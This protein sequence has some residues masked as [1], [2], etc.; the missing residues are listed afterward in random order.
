MAD[1]VLVTGAGGCLGAWAVRLLMLEGTAVVGLDVSDDSHRLRML[2]DDDEMGRV[3]LRRGDLR[4]QAAVEALIQ[5]EGITHIV[6]L[7]ALQVPFCRADPVLGAQV[8][9]TGTVNIFEAAR[10]SNGAVRGISYASSVAVFGPADMYPAGVAHD[11]SPLAPAT[12]YGVYKQAN[13]WTAK[14]YAADW[15]IGSVGLRPCVVYGPGRDQ[16]LTSDPTKAMLAAATGHSGHI[17][18]GGSSTFQHAEDAAA[19]FIA[20]SRLERS[21]A[22]VYN[23]SGPTVGIAELV[24]AIDAT[25]P[26]IATTFDSPPLPFPGEIDGSGLDAA[27]TVRHRPLKAGVAEAVE[28]FRRLLAA[29]LI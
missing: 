2:L 5:K 14:V 27:I 10:R 15:G 1:R 12:L 8:N 7:A 24:E 22:H 19:C 21:S 28:H 23:M 4:D 13:E 16:G 17:A 3:G 20:A 6:H 29:G 18:F 11:D 9:V 25:G 26:G